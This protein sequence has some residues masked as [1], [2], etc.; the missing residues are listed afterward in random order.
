MCRNKIK[1]R[2]NESKTTLRGTNGPPYKGL[3]LPENIGDKR[4]AKVG[5]P[6]AFAAYTLV[7]LHNIRF[8]KTAFMPI[9][10]SIIRS[11]FTYVVLN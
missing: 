2:K 8:N 4:K 10:R 3:Y 6:T 1:T 7:K 5:G 9:S 11:L